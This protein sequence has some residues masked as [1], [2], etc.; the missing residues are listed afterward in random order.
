MNIS[1][2]IVVSAA[3]VRTGGDVVSY[4]LDH[5]SALMVQTRLCLERRF[6]EIG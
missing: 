6:A 2:G 5:E 4:I 1:K 3:V